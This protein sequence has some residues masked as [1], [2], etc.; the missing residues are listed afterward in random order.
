[1]DGTELVIDALLGTGSR[2][3][4]RGA[5]GEAVTALSSTGIPVL[6]VDIPSGLDGDTGQ[7]PG[8]CVEAQTTVTMGL[9]KTG[10]YFPPG[11]HTVGRL[12]VAD[13]GFPKGLLLS[14]PGGV[15]IMETSDLPAVLPT[16]P[17][18]AHKGD[19]GRALVV[20]GSI[21]MTG[22]AA[23]AC[24][25]ALRVGAGL[26]YLA[27]PDSLNTIV[28]TLLPEVITIPLPE[29]DG[30]HCIDG[31]SRIRQCLE[32]ADVLLLGP[33]IGRSPA[34]T[35]L[36]HQLLGSWY[37][38]TV[39]DADGLYH[40]SPQ[41]TFHPRLLLTPHFGEMARLTGKDVAHL[42][43][44]RLSGAKAEALKR[45]A[46]LLLK[47]MPTVIVSQAM[48]AAINITGNAGL[49]TGGSGDVLAG[50]VTGLMAQS[51]ETFPAAQAAAFLHGLAADRLAESMPHAAILPSD[52]LDILPETL[53]IAGYGD[54]S[55]PAP[56]WRRDKP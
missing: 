28:E 46:S 8:T 22:A 56:W 23:L 26:V 17:S 45:D 2:G 7:I 33:G 11:C 20:A 51:A 43:G 44:D 48:R 53:R 5:I 4:P 15:E 38:P 29:S 31:F 55:S 6:S 32:A 52:L 35:D 24:N 37:G 49:A 41:M 50:I 10:M 14:P 27:I 1:L 36:V 42:L 21:G 13:I 12:V 54:R 39:L 18:T 9:A 30:S 47:G 19:C 16:I 34:T 25:A 3:A 40:V